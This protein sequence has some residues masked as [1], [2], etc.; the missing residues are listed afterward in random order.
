MDSSFDSLPGEVR[1]KSEEEK[2]SEK[3]SDFMRNLL[4]PPDKQY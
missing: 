3:I 4:K 2:E 1:E